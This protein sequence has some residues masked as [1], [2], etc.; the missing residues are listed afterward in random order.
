MAKREKAIKDKVLEKKD[1]VG[2]ILDLFYA[3]IVILSIAI[4]V[5]LIHI[6][7]TYSVDPSVENIFRPTG[8]KRPETPTR[9]AILSEDGR[10]LAISTPMYQVYMDCAVR[11]DD[12]KSEGEEGAKKEKNGSS[13]QKSFP[14]A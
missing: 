4:I 3:G 6:Q 12:F 13:L 10:I 1:R 11:K 2:F 14:A 9:G 5:K 8:T 7:L